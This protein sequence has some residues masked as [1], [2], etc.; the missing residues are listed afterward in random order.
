MIIYANCVIKKYY[1][2]YMAKAKPK[3][4]NR[5]TPQHAAFKIALDDLVVPASIARHY[6]ITWN[7]GAIQVGVRSAESGRFVSKSAVKKAA[8]TVVKGTTSKKAAPKT[9]IKKAAK[10]SAKKN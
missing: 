8:K 10:S 7:R 5:E 6:H 3:I 1:I 9:A 4:K 2:C